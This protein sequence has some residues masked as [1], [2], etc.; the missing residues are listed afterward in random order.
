MAKPDPVLLDP[1][2]YPFACDIT[3]R[4]SDLDTNLHIN[5]A[6]L[7][8]MCEDARVRFHQASG[9][10]AAIAEA[11]GTGAMIAS[12][13]IEYLG[14]AFHPDPLTIHVAAEQIGRTSYSLIQ[15]VRQAGRTVAFTRATMVVVAAGRSTPIPEPFR[16]SV[17][18]WM[19]RS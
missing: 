16:T 5:N 11:A 7:A 2:R 13:A 10:H 4:F 9:Y 3:T 15:L 1:A 18:P 12:F 19:F 8:G 17:V 14:E 6:A